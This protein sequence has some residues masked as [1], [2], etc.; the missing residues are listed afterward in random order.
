[1]KRKRATVIIETEKGILLVSHLIFGKLVF[2]LPGGGIK[3]SEKSEDAARREIFE[4]T[5]LKINKIKFLF[6]YKTFLHNHFVFKAEASGN[7]R[8]SWETRYFAFYEDDVRVGKSFEKMIEKYLSN[9][10]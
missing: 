4:E 7:L 2:A 10:R 3:F 8:K 5:G 9:I 6:N 1:M